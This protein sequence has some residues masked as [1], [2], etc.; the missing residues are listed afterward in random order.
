MLVKNSMSMDCWNNW[1]QWLSFQIRFD[2]GLLGRRATVKSS[3]TLLHRGDPAVHGAEISLQ[4]SKEQSEP[5][6]HCILIARCVWKTDSL[7]CRACSEIS[8]QVPWLYII[9]CDGGIICDG[10]ENTVGIGLN[11]TIEEVVHILTWSRHCTSNILLFS[12]F[13]SFKSFFPSYT[14]PSGQGARNINT[15]NEGKHF[16]S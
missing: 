5:T 13:S 3:L 16:L 2:W 6:L 14:W 7:R 11:F 8:I 10:V 15:L 1:N 9:S 4:T 12:R